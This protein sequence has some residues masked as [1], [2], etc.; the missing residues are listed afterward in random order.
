MWER[1]HLTYPMGLHGLLQRWLYLYLTIFPICFYFV[2][3][4]CYLCFAIVSI[5]LLENNG[6]DFTVHS[7]ITL[8]FRFIAITAADVKFPFIFTYQFNSI[9]LHKISNFHSVIIQ[10]NPSSQLDES[11]QNWCTMFWKLSLSPVT[12]QPSGM[13]HHAGMAVLCIHIP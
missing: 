4:V 3:L 7:S 2:V 5:G 1:G 6:C 12:L 10:W 8:H 9:Q 11:M 13:I